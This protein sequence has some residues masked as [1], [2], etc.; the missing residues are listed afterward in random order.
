MTDTPRRLPSIPAY[1]LPRA[2]KHNLLRIAQEATTNAVRHAS[3]THIHVHLRYAEDAVTLSIADDGV[4]FDPRTAM[5]GNVGHFGLRGIRSRSRKL[6]GQ[7]TIQSA[8]GAGATIRVVLPRPG[9]EEN[10]S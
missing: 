2:A 9:L 7:L 10:Q 6:N 8:P 3:A 1:A 4:G 5:D